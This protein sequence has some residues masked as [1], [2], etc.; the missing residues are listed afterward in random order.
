MWGR[1]GERWERN[2]EEEE[3]RREQSGGKRCMQHCLIHPFFSHSVLSAK[4][5]SFILVPLCV[6]ASSF[7]YHAVSFSMKC[8]KAKKMH[9]LCSCCTIPEVCVCL[10]KCESD[11]R[12][13]LSEPGHWAEK[14][15][16]QY[17]LTAF[18][19]SQVLT[20]R[21]G[22]QLGLNYGTQSLIPPGQASGHKVLLYEEKWK[23]RWFCFFK[24]QSIRDVHFFS[25]L[26]PHCLIVP[27]S[28]WIT[29]SV[30]V[31]RDAVKARYVPEWGQTQPAKRCPAHNEAAVGN[32]CAF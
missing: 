14:A 1:E 6:H 18:A 24:I 22:A 30:S 9:I 31:W 29:A 19:P 20:Q 17:W 4:F 27:R 11:S 3:Q 8:K 32:I 10:S 23:Q 12:L 28:D 13:Q 21:T 5:S 15:K 2:R 7:R 26:S 25:A 16:P